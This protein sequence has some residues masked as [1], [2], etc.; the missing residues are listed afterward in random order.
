MRRFAKQLNESLALADDQQQPVSELRAAL[1]RVE[2]DIRAACPHLEAAPLP[3]RLRIMQDRL[4]ALRVTAINL[5]AP[6]QKFQ[7]ALTPEQ[8]TKLATKQ[9]AKPDESR[10][11]QSDEPAAQCYL[12]AQ[13]APQWPAEKV[14][15]ILR[16]NKEQQSEF[17]VLS[18]TSSQM[19]QLMMGSCPKQALS[20]PSARLDATLDWIDS[21]LFAAANLAVLVD[22]FYANL[23][24]EQ[25]ERLDKFDL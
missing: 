4:W 11:N 23:N 2:K 18:K 8:R 10:E 20:T 17:G 19:G 21:L 12:L 16:L 13:V 22:A 25:K 14:M 9:P 5:R 3:E 15:R 24:G 6:L 1:Q 7:D